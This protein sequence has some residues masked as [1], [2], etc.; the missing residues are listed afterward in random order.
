MRS[1]TNHFGNKNRKYTHKLEKWLELLGFWKEYKGDRQH[2]D[3]LLF[4][5]LRKMYAYEEFERHR[6]AKRERCAALRIFLQQ[7]PSECIDCVKEPRN[8][9]NVC[10]RDRRDRFAAKVL[11][12]LL[13]FANKLRSFLSIRWQPVLVNLAASTKKPALQDYVSDEMEDAIHAES[14]LLS[15]YIDLLANYYQGHRNRQSNPKETY[16]LSCLEVEGILRVD[17]GTI[18]RVDATISMEQGVE[19]GV[20]ESNNN[21]D[22]D[23]SE[24]SDD[25]D[26]SDYIENDNKKKKKKAS[27]ILASAVVAGQK[28][29][30]LASNDDDSSTH[31]NADVSAPPEITEEERKPST[32]LCVK[33]Q[34]D[35]DASS[36][37]GDGASQYP[38]TQEQ[39]VRYLKKVP[40]G[41]PSPFK[42]LPDLMKYSPTQDIPA[43]LGVA[44]GSCATAHRQTSPGLK[45]TGTT[46][47]KPGWS[48]KRGYPSPSPYKSLKP[49]SP[50]PCTTLKPSDSPTDHSPP[51]KKVK[52]ETPVSTPRRRRDPSKRK[53]DPPT[54]PIHVITEDMLPSSSDDEKQPA[55]EPSQQHDPEAERPRSPPDCRDISV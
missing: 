51:K 49:T 47:S 14:Q 4:R 42:K 52:E 7:M 16:R 28:E 34:Q 29:A 22:F 45:T 27:A 21:N 18:E 23:D 44:R 26:D 1:N 43:D 46:K 36:L 31:A 50:P 2:L 48:S 13:V 17:L 35:D 12:E 32:L 25:S 37:E 33:T 38:D 6:A 8:R 19:Q 9:G 53:R 39:E 11:L 40:F 10:D 3:S 15:G 24:E 20:D 54:V 41:G 5:I 55:A 30:S